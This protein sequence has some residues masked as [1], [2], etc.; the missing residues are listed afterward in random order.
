MS[1]DGDVGNTSY[2]ALP[3][4][5]QVYNL[6]FNC[7]PDLEPAELFFQTNPKSPFND[8]SKMALTREDVA[9]KEKAGVV[10]SAGIQ[11]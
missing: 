2:T 5:S 3:F 11:R 4:Q 1:A 10:P 7:S 9:A 8:P 6:C